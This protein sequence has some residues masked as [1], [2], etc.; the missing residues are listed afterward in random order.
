[1]EKEADRIE[2]RAQAEGAFP[3]SKTTREY[4]V[5]RGEISGIN[6]ALIALLQ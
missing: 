5:K 1:M 2:A 3:S 4:Y 6:E